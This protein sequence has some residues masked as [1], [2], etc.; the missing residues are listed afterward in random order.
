MDLGRI[1]QY[2]AAAAIVLALATGALGLADGAWSLAVPALAVACVL[3][4][5]AGWA[6]RRK[7]RARFV[8]KLRDLLPREALPAAGEEPEPLLQCLGQQLRLSREERLQALN[9]LARIPFPCMSVIC[10]G[11]VRWRNEAM[12]SLMDEGCLPEAAES[13]AAFC[14]RTSAGTWANLRAGRWDGPW[15]RVARADGGESLFQVD[16]VELGESE[17]CWLCFFQDMTRRHR[18]AVRTEA[19]HQAILQKDARIEEK[20]ATLETLARD[21]SQTLVALV[22]S[23]HDSRDQAGQ[24]AQAMQEMTDNVRMMATMAAETA[25]TATGAEHR[26]REG[27]GTVEQ[28]AAVTRKVVASYDHLQGILSQ[29]L[30]KAGNIGSVVNLISDIADQTNLL[31]LN[32]AIEAARAGEYGRGFAVVADE[33][34]KLAEKTLLATREVQG[35][36]A[37]IG[38]CTHRA[39]TAMAETH[40]DIRTS[41]GLVLSVEGAF[42]AIAEAMVSASQGI[43][44]IARR[45]EQQCASSFEINMCAMNVTDNSQEVYDQVY[46]T[47]QELE[48]LVEDVS[49]VR[50]L[51]AEVSA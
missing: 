37:A 33:V 35:A 29:L 6:A 21:I 18:D 4:I 10:S 7:V 28:S 17:G 50:G 11:S 23:M 51:A 16:L 31:A 24:V 41:F 43:D 36:V 2:A 9:V 5:L 14:A 42:T 3:A 49:R 1:S 15:L 30:E 39:V 32:A 22:E 26:A 44:D 8:G 19:Q 34:R 13:V 12:A 25:Q 27:V 47:S 46:R 20:T 40:L 45:A 38:S 48:R